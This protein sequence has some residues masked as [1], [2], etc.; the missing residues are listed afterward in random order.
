MI[1]DKKNLMNE[2][3]K[4]IFKDLIYYE[5]KFNKEEKPRFKDYNNY[6][7]LV[8]THNFNKEGIWSEGKISNLIFK[9]NYKQNDIFFEMDVLPFVNKKI[10]S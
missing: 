4:K 2:T 6:I 9:I 7:C 8:W 1:K 10:M 5:P 3:D